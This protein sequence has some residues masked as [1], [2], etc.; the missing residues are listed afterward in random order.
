MCECA[1]MCVYLSVCVG[2]CACLCVHVYKS[3]TL[4]TAPYLVL[5]RNV[6]VK[7]CGIDQTTHSNCQAV[8][9]AT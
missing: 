1:C 9:C 2:V 8:I 6:Q 4:D 7:K 5:Y 3:S